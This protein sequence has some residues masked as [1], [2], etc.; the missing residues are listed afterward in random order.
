MLLGSARDASVG[1]EIARQIE[2]NF[3]NLI[4]K[5]TLAELITTL[6]ACRLLV[7]NDTGTMHL[8]AYLGVPT[9]SIFGSTE[10]ALT[11]PLGTGHRVLRHHVGCSPCF[12]RNCPLDFRCMKSVEAGEVVEAVLRM[13]DE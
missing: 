6:S 7:T 11:G 5:T 10:P 1:E 13:L 4:G 8:A 3:S 9:V 12:L 2:G